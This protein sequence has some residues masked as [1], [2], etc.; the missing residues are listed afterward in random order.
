[1]RRIKHIFFDSFY[2]VNSLMAVMFVLSNLFLFFFNIIKKIL[3]KIILL[4]NLIHKQ[5][6]KQFKYKVH[7]F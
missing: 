6:K 2:L 3:T 7:T 1:M 5:K 4:S